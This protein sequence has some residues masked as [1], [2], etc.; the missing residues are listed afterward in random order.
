VRVEWHS[1]ASPLV[2]KAVVGVGAV[3][4]ALG[5]RLAALDD[6]ALA[7]LAAVAGDG[8]LV[9]LGEAKA[10]PWVDGVTYLGSDATA[11]DLLVPATFAPDVPVAL[12]A[13]AVRRR[14][15]S[16]LVAVT[17]ERIIPC[18]TARAIS[19]AKLAEWLA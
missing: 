9:V 14:A 6:D 7:G 12:L 4:R 16:S 8:V 5:Q 11:P 2:A 19:R 15:A 1:R 18:G 3:A 10:L 17:P 13:Q